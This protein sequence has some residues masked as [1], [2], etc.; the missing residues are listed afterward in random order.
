MEE[1]IKRDIR[2]KGHVK[3][4]LFNA[5]TGELE[6]MQEGENYIHPVGV[7]ALMRAQQMQVGGGINGWMALSDYSFNSSHVPSSTSTNL[8]KF[9]HINNDTH[10]EN[11]ATDKRNTAVKLA[12]VDLTTAYAGADPSIGTIN[13]TESYPLENKVKIVCDFATDKA[14]GT[15][16]SV[17]LTATATDASV[18]ANPTLN[19]SMAWIKILHKSIGFTGVNAGQIPTT[20]VEDATHIYLTVSN[21]MYKINKTTGAQDAPVTIGIS[22]NCAH[23]F[24]DYIYYKNTTITDAMRRY[25]IS[26]GIVTTASSVWSNSGYGIGIS[27]DGTNIIYIAAPSNANPIY[28]HEI[29]VTTFDRVGAAKTIP[30][31]PSVPS[32][33]KA[34]KMDGSTWIMSGSSGVTNNGTYVFSTNVFTGNTTYYNGLITLAFANLIG[35]GLVAPLFYKAELRKNTTYY[36]VF[37]PA[38]LTDFAEMYTFLTRKLLGAPV[39]KT[40]L[41]S[42]KITYTITFT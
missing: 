10:A 36:R 1:I 6:E 28:A 37:T 14:N 5:K 15:F 13:E 24:G 39:T 41:Q 30:T 29:S 40:N 25:R 26:T 33:Y 17:Y 16:Q 8:F 32:N 38:S 12:H 9:M 27:D 23:L 35:A 34:I 7:S 31:L 11:S 18:N 2:F 21:L 42:M 22:V 4:E 3:V 20:A 19:S